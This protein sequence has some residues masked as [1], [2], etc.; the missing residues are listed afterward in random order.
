MRRAFFSRG[1]ETVA[2]ELL[3]HRLVYETGERL[4]GRVV[5]TEA[6]HGPDDPA[7]HASGGKTERNSPMFEKPGTAYIYV[8]YGIHR[9]LNVVTGEAGE[10]SA[11]LIR[12]VE[13]LEG[14]ERM[15]ENRGVERQELCNGPGKLTEAFRISEEH[16]RTDLTGGDLR[17]GE[18]EEVEDVVEDTRIGVSG[19]ED[20]ELR[21]YV[22]GNRFVSR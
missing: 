15:K 8:S 7:S 18:G 6:Y 5:E 21:F 17:I 4:S 9:M 3:G 12:A 11:V 1:P 16:N 14:I 22:K 2:R 13:P 10:P 20:M 19:G